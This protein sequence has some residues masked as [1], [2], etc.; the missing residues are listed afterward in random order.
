M[1]YGLTDTQVLSRRGGGGEHHPRRRTAS[2]FAARAFHA[3]RRARGR[4]RA[5]A[6]RTQRAR[7]RADRERHRPQATRRRPS[8]ARRAGGGRD[9]GIRYGRNRRHGLHRSRRDAGV[10]LCGPCG[11]RA[12]PQ[13]SETLFLRL[14]G[15]RRG[16][17]RPPA[18]GNLRSWRPGRPR[19]LW[20]LRL[21]DAIPT[22]TTGDLPSGRIRRSPRRSAYRR[23][24]RKASRSSAL[25]RQW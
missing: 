20:R 9:Q 18:R 11:G 10:P 21:P 14:I 19:T 23:R 22:R 15:Q 16:H 24:T 7:N 4:A 6:P 13:Q 25:A 17:R 3:A 1:H 2:H 12:P 8:G 5:Q